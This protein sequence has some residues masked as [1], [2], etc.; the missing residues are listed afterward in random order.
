MLV[1][2]NGTG[3]CFLKHTAHEWPRFECVP[4]APRNV[5]HFLVMRLL[6][7]LYQYE[8]GHWLLLAEMY[9]SLL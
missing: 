7:V 3:M 4:M 8:W 9:I 2:L 5:V 6:V 1:L